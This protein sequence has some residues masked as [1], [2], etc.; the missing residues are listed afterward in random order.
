[1]EDGRFRVLAHILKAVRDSDPPK[2]ENAVIRIID[3]FKEAMTPE[4]SAE[5]LM[6]FARY[7]KLRKELEAHGRLEETLE[8][9]K[10]RELVHRQPFKEEIEEGDY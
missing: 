5:A 6:E 1:M 7:E 10:Y 9:E 3:A 8:E 2:L 4:Q